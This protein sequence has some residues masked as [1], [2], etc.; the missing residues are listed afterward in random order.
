MNSFLEAFLWAMV[1]G[2]II[3]IIKYIYYRRKGGR[4]GF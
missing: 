2:I 1:C 3:E 4:L